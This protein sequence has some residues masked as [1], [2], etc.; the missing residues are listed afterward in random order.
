M[1]RS[2]GGSALGNEQSVELEAAQGEDED[3]CFVC[4]DVGRDENPLLVDTCACRTR[5]HA[6]CQRRL[7]L[8]AQDSV[9][10][11]C[12]TQ[13]RNVD[14]QRV[15]AVRVRVEPM[16]IYVAILV[17]IATYPVLL[18]MIVYELVKY[19]NHERTL[20]PSYL[21]GVIWCAVVIFSIFL[22]LSVVICVHMHTRFGGPARFFTV[23][24]R[25][26][27]VSIHAPTSAADRV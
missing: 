18:Y 5:I 2:Q 27:T 16:T 10:R 3:V 26:Q 8:S 14:V 22:G 24:H 9:C 1:E 19:Y 12:R 23:T 15:P 11:V 4:Y 21:V 13:Y 6:E 7:I 25:I 20:S 17:L